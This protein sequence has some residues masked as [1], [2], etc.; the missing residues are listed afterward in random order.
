MII[1]DT[2]AMCPFTG[3]IYSINYEKYE[4]VLEIELEFY[5]KGTKRSSYFNLMLGV[6]YNYDPIGKELAKYLKSAKYW[7]QASNCGCMILVFKGNKANNRYREAT[8]LISRLLRN[9]K[10]HKNYN[11]LITIANEDFN[12][13][14]GVLHSVLFG[15]TDQNDSE[16]IKAKDM[17][18][19]FKEYKNAANDSKR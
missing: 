19:R 13:Y 12:R 6:P 7:S 15:P 10:A 5:L 11:K 14:H 18:T 9:Q 1:S 16:L 3:V 2:L 4:Y 17:F 8:T